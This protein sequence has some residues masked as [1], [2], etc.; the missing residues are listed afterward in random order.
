MEKLDH[1][2][3]VNYI[4]KALTSEG[5]LTGNKFMTPALKLNPLKKLDNREREAWISYMY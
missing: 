5:R 3:K 4:L 1:L 2:V